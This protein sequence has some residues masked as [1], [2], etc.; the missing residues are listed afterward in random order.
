M[1]QLNKFIII[2]LTLELFDS[3][4]ASSL[5]DG[6]VQSKIA[7]GLFAARNQFPYHVVLVEYGSPYC[8]GSIIHPYFVLTVSF[9][10]IHLKNVFIIFYFRLLIVSKIDTQMNFESLYH[11]ICDMQMKLFFKQNRKNIGIILYTIWT[12]TLEEILHLTL[13]WFIFKMPQKEV[14]IWTFKRNNN[15]KFWMIYL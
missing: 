14:R 7:G 12:T 8:G 9:L 15:Y 13:D 6:N 10:F 2:L 4:T 3:L 5:K 11:T 1:N